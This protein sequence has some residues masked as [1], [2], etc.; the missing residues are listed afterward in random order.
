[1]C[2][3]PALVLLHVYIRPADSYIKRFAFTNICP[4]SDARLCVLHPGT[5]NLVF[6]FRV[7]LTKSPHL[8]NQFGKRP[9][10]PVFPSKAAL[11]QFE[12]GSGLHLPI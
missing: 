8:R 9:Q 5:C 6:P 3:L 11:R 4:A 10:L 2:S 1:M 12:G 7:L